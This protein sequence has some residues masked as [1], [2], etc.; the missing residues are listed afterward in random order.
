MHAL[1]G[2][3]MQASQLPLCRHGMPEISYVHAIRASQTI[4]IKINLLTF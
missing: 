4:F 2:A 3:R 1:R